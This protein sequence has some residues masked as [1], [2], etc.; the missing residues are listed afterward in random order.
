MTWEQGI[1]SFST[2]FNVETVL[3]PD[4][5]LYFL[6]ALSDSH[7]RAATSLP[8]V[9]MTA[10]YAFGTQRPETATPHLPTSPSR[11]QCTEAT[12]HPTAVTLASSTQISSP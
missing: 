8:R 3:A 6:D 9:R 4:G 2:K 12:H 1:H 11:T 7:H 5:E 10:W